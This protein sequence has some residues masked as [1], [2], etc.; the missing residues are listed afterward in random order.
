M[1]EG[2]PVRLIQFELPFPFGLFS[3]G[4]RV[5]SV[6]L[7]VVRRTPG[8]AAPTKGSKGFMGHVHAGALVALA[9][10]AA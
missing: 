3:G 9:C 6:L 5:R 8:C 7:F 2:P 10:R 1:A 4:G